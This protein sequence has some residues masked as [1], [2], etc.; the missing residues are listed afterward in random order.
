MSWL[1]D[2]V[3]DEDVDLTKEEVEATERA[4]R[5]RAQGQ[6]PDAKRSSADEVL[7]AVSGRVV[8]KQDLTKCPLCGSRTKVRGNTTSMTTVTRRCT[9]AACKNE[10]PVASVRSRTAMPPMFPDPMIH[11]GPYPIGPNRGNSS[12]PPID[13]YQPVQKRLSEFAR[14]IHNDGE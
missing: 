6:S 3:P 14:R 12:L 7:D 9:N 1:M 11:G 8:K 10:Y 2:H 4:A 5:A 13:P